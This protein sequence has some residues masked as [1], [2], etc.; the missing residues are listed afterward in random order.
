VVQAPSDLASRQQASLRRV[1]ALVARGA[2]SSQ[3]FEAVAREVAEVTGSALVQIQRFEPDDMVTVAGAWGARPHPFKP[4]S[5]WSLEGS[6][7]AAKIKRTGK[8]VRIDDF[9]A[10]SGQIQA[11][12]RKTGIRGGAGAPIFV[13]GELWGVMAAGPAEGEP[14]P[15]GLEGVLAGFT[16]LAATAIAS[17]ESRA[18]LTRLA[19]EQA[20]LRRVATL[21]AQGEAPEEVFAAVGDELAALVDA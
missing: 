18:A 19:D 8:V 3:V 7:I 15:V 11:G 9:G 20:A 16:E 4:G 10:G 21:V 12:V 2:E 17:T 5:K 1:A 6:Q 14:V 13:A